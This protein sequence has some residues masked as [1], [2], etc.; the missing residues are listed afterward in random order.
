MGEHKFDGARNRKPGVGKWKKSGVWHSK[1]VAK[2]GNIEK[3]PV[4]GSIDYV[5]YLSMLKV[6]D[7]L[8]P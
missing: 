7:Y 4:A 8:V 6:K 2:T 1:K 3:S 5:R